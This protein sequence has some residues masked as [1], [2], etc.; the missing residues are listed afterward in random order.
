MKIGIVEDHF[1][2]R[3]IIKEKILPYEDIHIVIEAE[4]GNNFFDL[5]K[6]L[7]KEDYPQ[8]VLIDL[9]MPV[10][11]G[12]STISLSS[13]RYPSIKFIVLTIYEDNDKIFDAIK[14]GASG[15]LLKE[16]K[17]I[18]IVDA[19]ANV[20]EYDGI[21]MSPAIARRAMKLLSGITQNNSTLEKIEDY[22]LSSREIQILKEIVGGNNPADIA[23]KLFI[24]PNTVRTHVNNIYKKLHLN[25]RAQVISLA[26]KN[27]WI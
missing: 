27:N 24:S 16:D 13:I 8:V 19:I 1:I 20:I 10:L 17:A 23:E 21:P 3:K 26:H 14:A 25:S 2:N 15:Y 9:E 5:M 11:D 7:R 12:I 6:N 18:N 4:N 22:Q